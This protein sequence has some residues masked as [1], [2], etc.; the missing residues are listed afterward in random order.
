M[1]KKYIIIGV[2]VLL[3]VAF[4]LALPSIAKHQIN[5]TLNE[6]DGYHGHLDEIRLA[7]IAGQFWM[8][9]LKIYEE[10]AV[11]STI[12]MI[13]LPSLWFSI[14]WRS[15]FRGRIVATIEIDSLTVNL[16]K[17]KEAQEDQVMENRVSFAEQVQEM[18]PITIN[19]IEITNANILYRNPNAEPEI[20]I[21]LTDFNLHA[22][23]LR[24]VVDKKDTLPARYNMNATFMG[25]GQLFSEGRL[26]VLKETPDFDIDFQVEGAE[27]KEIE[28][29]T[30][31]HANLKI[32]RGLL[33]L[34]L[35]LVAMD[36]N[37]EG[38]VKPLMEGV[39]IQEKDDS[40]VFQKIYESVVQ[41]VVNLLENPDEDHVGARVEI[42]GNL[43]DPDVSVWEILNSLLINAFVE[44]YNRELERI[45]G[46]SGVDS[47]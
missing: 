40:G 34:Y 44:A 30:D 41:G 18:N 7:L 27:V 11:D 37:V 1:K 38:Y 15:L 9:G 26:N 22:S 35:E 20:D 29:Y 17:A 19:T 5:K 10:T 46:L 42:E 24:N 45:I 31:H 12:P 4:R 25:T 14:E 39:E 23:N 33:Y 6:I 47:G 43:N 28:E 32:E 8:N 13:D 21:G 3:I 36:G 2:V 16:V